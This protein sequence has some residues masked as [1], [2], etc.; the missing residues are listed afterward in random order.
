MPLAGTRRA[1]LSA[2]LRLLFLALFAAVSAQA[3]PVPADSSA[4]PADSSVAPEADPFANALASVRS[5]PFE[6]LAAPLTGV[7]WAAP[8]SVEAAIDDLVA[9]RQAGVRAVRTGLLPGRVLGAADRL[10]I[11]VAQELPI[12]DLPA[13]RLIASLPQAEARF[14]RALD[15]ARQH[16]SAR[17]FI[18]A[19]GVDTSDLR[20]R[21]YFERLSALA[22]E[23]GPE[24]TRTAYL[25]RFVDDDRAADAVDLVLLDARGTDPLA[26]LRRW[27]ARHDTPVG[28]GAWGMGVAPGREG[29][30][31]RAGTEAHQ[32]RTA[33]RTLD[34][35]LTMDAPPEAAFLSR[36][37]D[38]EER[39]VRAEVAGLRYGLQDAEGVR[40]PAMS[41]ASGV[42][43]GRQRVF[44]F[45]AGDASRARGSGLLVLL[46]WALALG[47]GALLA[48]SPRLGGLVPQ[49]FGRRDLYREAIQKGYGLSGGV[50]AGLA[51]FLSLAVGL[52]LATV[53][54]AF[55][56]TDALAVATAGWEADAQS[57]LADLLGSAAL[58][59]LLLAVVY[60]AWLLFNVVWVGILAGRRRRLRTVQAL[61]LVVWTRWPWLLLLIGAMAVASLSGPAAGPWAATLLVLALVIESIAAYRTMVDLTYVGAVSPARAL[62]IGFAFPFLL[63]LIAAVAFLISAGAELGFL[64]HLAVR[65]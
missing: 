7:V 41:V 37:R 53:V 14:A 46:G 59:G 15:L 10:G 47:L 2:V 58:L 43:T 8:D 19:R 27:R 48:A 39:G 28:L 38:R 17:L 33:E 55:G 45:D 56:A 65:S 26:L 31:R 21:P 1:I 9:M 62:G 13:E 52:V 25:T 18:L 23:R 63:L 16:P 6:P 44:A 51:A 3:Q 64:W 50:T 11:A 36:W 34:A 4:T 24:G 35:L 29:G 20:A 54:R 60:A 32:A 61:S 22:R 57:R 42:F 40:R 5:G 12:A 30:W 49:Y